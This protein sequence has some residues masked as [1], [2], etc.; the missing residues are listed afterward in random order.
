MPIK[1][2]GYSNFWTTD[3]GKGVV[4]LL[5]DLERVAHGL[6]EEYIEELLKMVELA[7]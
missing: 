2:F 3:G 7:D 4:V 6:G 5:H 1:P